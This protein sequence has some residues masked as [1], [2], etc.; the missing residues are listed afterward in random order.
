MY[1]LHIHWIDDDDDGN[2]DDDNDDL[3]HGVKRFSS[4][5]FYR[6]LV[7]EVN[8]SKASM[9]HLSSTKFSLLL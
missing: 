8:R 5:S 3:A 7:D 2:G 6:L 4:A 9:C 1:H